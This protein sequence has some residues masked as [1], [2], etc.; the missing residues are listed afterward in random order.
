LLISQICTEHTHVLRILSEYPVY[1]M[2]LWR[3]KKKVLSLSG[4]AY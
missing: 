1:R 3:L 4:G 2:Y